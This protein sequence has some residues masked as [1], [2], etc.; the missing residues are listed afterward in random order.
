MMDDINRLELT[1]SLLELQ[2]GGTPSTRWG[3][4]GTS[5]INVIGGI[6]GEAYLRELQWP[7][8]I[9]IYNKIWRSDP[10]LSVVRLVFESWSGQQT[11]SAEVPDE[12]SGKDIGKP[13]DDDQKARDFYQSVLEDVEGGINRWLATCVARVPFY[14][15]GWW[16][17]VPGLRIPDWK[18]PGQDDWR[19]DYDDN[20]IG[21]RRLA[22]RNYSSFFGWE[23]DD[24]TGYITGMEQLDIPNPPVTI[25][26]KRSAHIRFGDMNNPEGLAT[27][28][29]VYRLERYKYQLEIVQGI[30]FEHA[31]GHSNFAA[32]EKLNED[33][34]L[35]IRR[36]A[37]AVATAQEGNYISLPGH[38]SH[39]FQDVPFSAAVA[40]M[41][42]IRYYGILKLAVW[43]QQWVAIATLAEGGAYAAMKDASDMAIGIYN[44]MVNGFVGQLDNQVGKQLFD[45]P[46]NKAAFPGMTRRPRLNVS[47]IRK[48]MPVAELSQLITALAAIMPFDNEDVNSIR[49]ETGFLSQKQ[50]DEIPEETAPVEENPDK[51][52]TPPADDEIPEPMPEMVMQLADNQDGVMVA[53]FVPPEVADELALKDIEG[54]LGPQELHVTLAFLGSASEQIASKRMLMAEIQRMAAYLPQVSGKIN[55]YGRFVETHIDGKDAVWL[56]FDA[57]ALP[58]FRERIVL[59]VERCGFSL[60]SD[61][62]FTP[63]I[64]LAYVDHDK[65][66]DFEFTPVDVV[67]D[68]VWLA[69]GNEAYAFHLLDG[70]GEDVGER[71]EELVFRPFMVSDKEQ[72]VTLEHESEITEKDINRAMRNFKK[73]AEENAPSIANILD[74]K[75][76]P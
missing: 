10:E 67:F 18:P 5:G 69:W 48:T 56:S 30:G 34:K 38:I 37:R 70:G 63:H 14:G 11:I 22:F 75:P 60:S 53:L 76:L 54:A 1:R 12:I 13:T 33:D 6:V 46:I 3:E 15:W 26:K 51:G 66:L 21:I 9:P 45:Y 71:P 58:D 28:E 44:S 62:G 39:V 57:P 47:P 41:T 19:S 65:A 31:A 29:A 43:G 49:L 40:L 55:G 4:I 25:P 52:E 17:S 50:E 16:E 24:A 42:A 61:H 59:C 20:L 2:S 73:W 74:A 72:P 23:M 7:A 8:C 35:L 36:S 27:M 68:K 32:T 64:T